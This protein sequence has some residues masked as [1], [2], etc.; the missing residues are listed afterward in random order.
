M[1]NWR[2][3]RIF[4]V[5]IGLILLCRRLLVS[6]ILIKCLAAL[7]NSALMEMLLP[8]AA[9]RANRM[10]PSPNLPS[11]TEVIERKKQK[12]I[13]SEGTELFNQDP[14]KGCIFNFASKNYFHCRLPVSLKA[15]VIFRCAVFNGEGNSED[16]TGPG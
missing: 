6:F 12:R 8:S 7:E 14:K 4:L 15:F 3:V 13:L 10:A 2:W 16:A 9:V 11:L 1:Y 5:C